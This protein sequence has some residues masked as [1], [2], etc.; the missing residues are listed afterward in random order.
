[1]NIIL[2]NYKNLITNLIKEL[3]INK[4]DSFIDNSNHYSIDNYVE[5]ISNFDNNMN[6]VITKSISAL[7]ED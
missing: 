7:F 4:I 5:L 6:I 2:Q 3:F 1:M